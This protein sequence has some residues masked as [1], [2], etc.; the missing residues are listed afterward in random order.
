M[1]PT[2][3]GK[4][5]ERDVVGVLQRHG[6]PDCERVLRMGAHDD[7][8]DI[9]G[10]PGLFIDCKDHQR[11]TLPQWL[12]EAHVE[13]VAASERRGIDLLPLLIVKRRGRAAAHSYAVMELI[14]AIQLMR[15]ANAPA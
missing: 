12:D 10:V 13:C 9:V 1:K 8:G 4:A 11:I 5:F 6:F 14:D 2:E 3:R 15:D 7:L